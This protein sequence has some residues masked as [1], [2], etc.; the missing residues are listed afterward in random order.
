MENRF[1]EKSTD[2]EWDV[3][4]PPLQSGAILHSLLPFLPCSCGQG[5]PLSL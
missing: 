4:G 3:K 5:S 2:A 1:L